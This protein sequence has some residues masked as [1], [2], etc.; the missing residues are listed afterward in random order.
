MAVHELCT[1]AVKYGALSN[2]K[3]CVEIIWAISEK[4]EARELQLRWQERDG[5]PVTAPARRGFGSRLIEQGLARDL[6]G[7][8]EINYAVT[9]LVCVIKA[10]LATKSRMLEL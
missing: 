6:A 4:K 10:S 9:G 7:E 1:N 5:P 8:V 2:G 3:G